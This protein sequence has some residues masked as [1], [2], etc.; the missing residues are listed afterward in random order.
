VEAAVTA[1]REPAPAAPLAAGPGTVLGGRFRLEERIGKGG[2]GHVYRARDLL[3]EQFDGEGATVAVKL[4]DPA[5]RRDPALLEAILKSVSCMRK[6][7]H[8][9]IAQVHELHRFGDDYLIVMEMLEGESLA[10][11]LDRAG[12]PALSRREFRRMVNAVGSALDYAHGYGTV[13][14]DIKPA[15]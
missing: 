12:H 14:G 2:T 9:D 8:P 3:V 1:W 6:L 15:N 11:R 5:I 13:H 4:L 10:R 7:R